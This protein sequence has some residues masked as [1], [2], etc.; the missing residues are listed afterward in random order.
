MPK[1]PKH[2]GAT[3]VRDAA[4]ERLSL[5]VFIKRELAR[6]KKAGLWDG[7]P[8]DPNLDPAVVLTQLMVD[9]RLAPEL[10]AVC[11]KTLLPYFHDDRSL[12]LKAEQGEGTE[13]VMVTIKQ[14][15]TPEELA[16]AARRNG[17][18]PAP[19]TIRDRNEPIDDASL[20]DAA[21]TRNRGTLPAPDPATPAGID[22][23][24]ASGAALY[25]IEKDGDG[26]ARPRHT[27]DVTKGYFEVR[28]D[29]HGIERLV[30]VDGPPRAYDGT[31]PKPEVITMENRK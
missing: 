12:L 13:Q 3:A 11:A 28:K 20:K 4:P 25:S 10:R 15:S 8:D 6:L 31:Q 21:L 27:A 7:N 2:K 14:Y 29:N 24:N 26:I 30:R 19:A 23:R 22:A 18:L 5:P 9:D 17:I 1:K 16:A